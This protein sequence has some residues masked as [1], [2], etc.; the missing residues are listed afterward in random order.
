MNQETIKSLGTIRLSHKVLL[1]KAKEICFGKINQ[2]GKMWGF[3]PCLTKHYLCQE[4]GIEKLRKDLKNVLSY[5][6]TLVVAEI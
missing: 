5:D 4:S 3:Q 2:L 6:V 1:D